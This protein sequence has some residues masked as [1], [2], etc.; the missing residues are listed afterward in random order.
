MIDELKSKVQELQ[1]ARIEVNSDERY[2]AIDRDVKAT[3]AQFQ[4]HLENW[5][6]G[7]EGSN[8]KISSLVKKLSPRDITDSPATQE[9]LKL[10]GTT[11][12]KGEVEILYQRD[13]PEAFQFAR[14]LYM[15]LLSNRWSVTSPTAIPDS[16]S[17]PSSIA[18]GATNSD[19]TILAGNLEDCQ[20]RLDTPYCVLVAALQGFG[21]GLHMRRN[22]ELQP[23]LFRIV[24][25][26]RW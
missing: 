18:A 11:S 9:A 8:E 25:G 20:S 23:N 19:L 26:P 17:M 13:D 10:L 21:L 4:M 6:K 1:Q 12:H 16:D 24:I 3:W 7:I 15:L 14:N 22:D 5:F 2:R